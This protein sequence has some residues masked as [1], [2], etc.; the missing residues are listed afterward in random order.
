MSDDTPP[1]NEQQPLGQ[2][3][4]L[5]MLFAGKFGPR[6]DS[7]PSELPIH[8]LNSREESFT[9]RTHAPLDPVDQKLYPQLANQPSMTPAPQTPQPSQLTSS[10]DSSDPVYL[11]NFQLHT[12]QSL[13]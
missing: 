4:F 7:M 8:R 2:R 3:S 12:R 10:N 13:R 9:S 5:Q 6:V 11:T 1:P